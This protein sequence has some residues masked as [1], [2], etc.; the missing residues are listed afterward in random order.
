M[1]PAKPAIS[2]NP[3]RTCGQRRRTKHSQTLHWCW[4]PRWGATGAGRGGS[5]GEATACQGPTEEQQHGRPN[6]SDSWVHGLT[7]G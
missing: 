3:T 7:F 2:N 4:R 1:I 5:G 6:S